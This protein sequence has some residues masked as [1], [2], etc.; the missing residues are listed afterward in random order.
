MTSC[1]PALRQDFNRAVALLHSFWFAAGDRGIRRRVVRRTP[2]ARSPH[3]GVALSRWGNPFAGLRS[4]KQISSGELCHSAGALA[5][6]AS[7][8]HASAH[9][10]PRPPSCYTSDDASTQRAHTS[11]R[12]GAWNGSF[13]RISG[14]HG[15]AH[16]LLSR[17][18]SDRPGRGDKKYSQQLKAAAIL[19]PLFKEHPKHPGARALHHSRL[20]HSPSRGEGARRS[21]RYARLRRR[22]ARAAHAVAYVHAAGFMERID[23]DH[24]RRSAE[25]AR[26][27]NC[28]RRRT[29]CDG[30]PGIRISADGKGWAMPGE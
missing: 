20:R 25:A 10:S 8:P 7:N 26:K 27:E 17:G 2:P 19:E 23:R 18:G 14:R 9:T 28:D 4:P 16:L 30:L 22:T 5:T 15:G 3:W 6:G 24:D 1:A 13:R 11:P 21:P 12:A 29:A